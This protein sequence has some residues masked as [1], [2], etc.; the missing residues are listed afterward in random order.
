MSAP[1][2]FLHAAGLRLDHPLS[3]TG[4]L[5]DDQRRIAEDA[6]L[7]AFDRLID[8]AIERQVD[9]VLLV[10]DTFVERDASLRAAAALAD[11]CVRL[12]EQHIRVFVLPGREDPAIAWQTLPEL[13][14]NVTLLSRDD[15]P[16]A[17]V[18]DG[19][20]VA[21]IARAE[22]PRSA[23]AP[24]ET[25]TARDE[26]TR[27][28]PFAI[29]LLSLDSVAVHARGRVE[30]TNDAPPAGEAA[31]T[32]DQP[33]Q[34]DTTL[35]ELPFDYVALGGGSSRQTIRTA[36]GVAHHPGSLQGMER[37]HIGQHGFTLVETAESGAVRQQFVPAAPVRWEEFILPADATASRERLLE[38]MRQELSACRC[39][40]GEQLWLVRWTTASA[41]PLARSLTD[42]SFLDELRADLARATG[43]TVPVR[44]SFR[45]VPAHAAVHAA[46]S[47]SPLD[48]ARFHAELGL[49]ARDQAA[50]LGRLDGC[51]PAAAA[52]LRSLVPH[53][54]TRLI[55][56]E[57]ARLGSL[58][59]SQA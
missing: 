54:D 7:T 27:R 30:R 1:L 43:L 9:F 49:P 2:R 53:L 8:V 52:R 38:L 47:D 36:A 21:T 14:P 5:P 34:P 45:L 13:P 31:G 16:L 15:D 59:F 46:R 56:D 24:M 37:R 50:A 28:R 25:G 33:D 4:P 12:A 35:Q 51:D 17:F 57:A 10:G 55:D 22:P 29:G 39:E 40:P 41:G 20:L 3:G 23:G 19:Q 11:G 26:T 48:F 6:T 58:V 42:D 32:P 18:R 44:H